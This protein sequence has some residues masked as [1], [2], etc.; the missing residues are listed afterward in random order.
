M[1][2]LSEARYRLI[3][4]D[5]DTAEAQVNQA[6][7][8]AQSLLEDTL[9]RSVETGTYTENLPLISD[10]ETGILACFPTVYPVVSTV[11]GLTVR[12][13]TVYGAS[14]VSS[15]VTPG[16][17]GAIFPLVASITYTAG[18]DPTV[19]DRN[20]PTFLPGY[21]ERD[22]AFV[23]YHLLRPAIVLAVP[24]NALNARS[25]D[26][27]VTYKDPQSPAETGVV[28]SKQT[29]SWKRRTI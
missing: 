3:T 20:D 11:D 25:G 23:A 17:Y 7:A 12:F 22:L 13:D 10:P 8:D 29:L 5:K 4:G 1:T 15:P 9:S 18:W 26:A 28:W 16:D 14:P 19:T 6:A 2:L 24:V 21:V 27:A